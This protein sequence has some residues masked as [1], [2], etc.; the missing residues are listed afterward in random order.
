MCWLQVFCCHLLVRCIHEETNRLNSKNST[1]ITFELCGIFPPWIR[2][3]YHHAWACTH[4][5]RHLPPNYLQTLIL[6]GYANYYYAFCHVFSTL[7]PNYSAH[8]WSPS[9]KSCNIWNYCCLYICIIQWQW[10]IL[11]II[12][13]IRAHSVP[14]W[15]WCLAHVLV[16]FNNV[17]ST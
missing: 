5:A 13:E 6:Q 17:Y 14:L 3:F 12:T 2:S 4:K 1:V 16:N 10:A 15:T 7:F 9:G 8:T 11:Q